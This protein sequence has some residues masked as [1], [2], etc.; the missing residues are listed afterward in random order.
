MRV[1]LWNRFIVALTGLLLLAAGILLALC[2]VG[3]TPNWLDMS[4]L[5]G[6]LTAT[7]QRI[8]TGGC[9]VLLC[10]LGLHNVWLLFQRK[11]NKGFIMQRTD[12]GDMSISMKALEA[13]V[14]KCV[15]QHRELEVKSTKIFRVKNGI[16]VQIRILLEAGVNIPLTVSALQKQIKQ[17]IISC[18]GVEVYEV[19]VLVE[20]TASQAKQ[21]H[22]KEQQEIVV[23][24]R[25]PDVVPEP[26]VIEKE[27]TAEEL[28]EETVDQAV[29]PEETTEAQDA[30]TEAQEILAEEMPEEE[31]LFA[32]FDSFVQTEMEQESA[33][34]EN[35]DFDFSNDN[36]EEQE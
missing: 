30:V 35:T 33:S 11:N 14:H 13:M 19:Q 22:S 6:K 1:K 15:G 10:L 7:W 23:D 8:A 28:P 2:S 34:A 24:N 4:W 21:N 26:I 25:K 27:E 18:S 31:N 5:E 9:G 29:L 32:D 17:Y 3:F 20:T 12:F 16:I 36:K